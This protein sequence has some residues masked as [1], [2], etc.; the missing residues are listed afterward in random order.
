MMLKMDSMQKTVDRYEKRMIELQK[1]IDSLVD[2]NEGQ[3]EQN[4]R[5]ST[6]ITDLTTLHQ[7][8]MPAVKNDLKK[9]EEKL[10]Y[11]FNEYWSEM[12]E[13]LDKLET[14]VSVGIVVNLISILYIANLDDESR[15]NSSSFA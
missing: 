3:R 7:H 10:L 4:E 1:Q 2:L 5:L 12:V 9:L 15:T 11:N 14:R 8:E 6:E 13:K